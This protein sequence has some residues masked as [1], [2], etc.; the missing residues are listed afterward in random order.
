MIIN[1]AKDGHLS[2]NQQT[3]TLEVLKTRL[4]RLG[5][6]FPG[7]PVVLRADRDTRY[8]DLMNVVDTCRQAN[9][10]NFS[11]ATIEAKSSSTDNPT[12]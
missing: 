11:M 10:W 12:K 7:Q 9:I 2:I 1:I 6:N 3:M 5:K 8:E 4:L